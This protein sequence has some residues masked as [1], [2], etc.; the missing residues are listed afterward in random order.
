[1]ALDC[2]VTDKTLRLWLSGE[3]WPTRPH[4]TR[5]RIWIRTTEQLLRF[6]P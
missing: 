2:E 4:A 1:M 6:R 3:R 5:V